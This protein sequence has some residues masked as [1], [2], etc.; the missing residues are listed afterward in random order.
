ERH[1]HRI[2]VVHIEELPAEWLGK[3]YASYRG[4][5]VATGEWLLFMDADVHLNTS[6]LQRA[7]NY[8]IQNKLDHLSV[9]AHYICHGFFY[10]VVNLVHKGHGLVIPLKP[11]LAKSKRSKK[12]LNLGVFCLIRKSIYDDFGGHQAI[13]NECIDDLK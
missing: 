10:N 3:N 13:A 1:K 2:K 11:W 5:N 8:I 4:A 9:L 7:M 12:S 6:T